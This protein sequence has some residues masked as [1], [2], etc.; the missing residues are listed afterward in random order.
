MSDLRED[1][2]YIMEKLGVSS[3]EMEKKTGVFSELT[4]G[5]LVGESE[6]GAE[7]EEVV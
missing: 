4:D 6:L 3:V 1:L 7:V 2:A 5:F